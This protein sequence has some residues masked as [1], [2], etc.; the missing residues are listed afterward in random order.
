LGDGD[1]KDDPRNLCVNVD[2]SLP[3]CMAMISPQDAIRR[4]EMYYEGGSLEYLTE[5]QD[6]VVKT[7]TRELAR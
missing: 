3:R 6:A 7:S 1:E 4:I 5:A 2:G